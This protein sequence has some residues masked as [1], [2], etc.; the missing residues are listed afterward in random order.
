M[1]NTPGAVGANTNTNTNINTTNQDTK[2]EIKEDNK[3]DPTPVNLNNKND[4]I[5]ALNNESNKTEKDIKD[6]AIE[7][8]P[9]EIEMYKYDVKDKAY[10]ENPRK[11]QKLSESKGYKSKK[12]YSKNTIINNFNIKIYHNTPVS[13][14]T[15][16]SIAKVLKKIEEDG[17]TKETQI[18]NVQIQKAQEVKRNNIQEP[19]QIFEDKGKKNK[20]SPRYLGRKRSRSKSRSRKDKKRKHHHH[21]KS[22]SRSRS[23]SRNKKR[24]DRSSSSSFYSSLGKFIPKN[25]DLNEG[26]LY[27]RDMAQRRRY[28]DNGYK[29]RK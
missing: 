20:R 8:P 9:K 19:G 28:N 2:L 11:T 18:E 25:L 21:S 4:I 29:T 14:S 17:G 16:I 22:Y 5:M 13:N 6:E 1:K 7:I 15:D 23:K 10:Y 26:G 27:S 24:R 12:S 3:N